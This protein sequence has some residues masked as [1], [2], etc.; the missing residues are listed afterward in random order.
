MRLN[1]IVESLHLLNLTEIKALKEAVKDRYT[2]LCDQLVS[3]VPG[4]IWSLIFQQLRK[5]E[6]RFFP[7]H[8]KF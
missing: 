2:V 5:T 3:S 8:L 6:A 1:D 7:P 4:D